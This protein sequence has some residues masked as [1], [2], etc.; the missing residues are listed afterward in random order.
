MP[1]YPTVMVL[2]RTRMWAVIRIACSATCIRGARRFGD[3]GRREISAVCA[4][5]PRQDLPAVRPLYGSTVPPPVHQYV[6]S[7]YGTSTRKVFLKNENFK[8]LNY[9][10]AYYTVP[11]YDTPHARYGPNLTQGYTKP[12]LGTQAGAES[13]ATHLPKTSEVLAH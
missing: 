5:L 1:R 11:G 7:T 3:I 6:Y 12:S 13:F 10:A 2:F 8:I 9:R 4:D